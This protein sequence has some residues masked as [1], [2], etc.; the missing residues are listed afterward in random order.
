[1][2]GKMVLRLLA[3][4]G[5]LSVAFTAFPEG[6][7]SI[8]RLASGHAV[9]RPDSATFAKWRSNYQ[10]APRAP[11]I[12][13]AKKFGGGTSCSL[14]ENLQYT[15]SERDQSSCGNCWVWAGTGVLEIA[16]YTQKST[17]DRLSIQ[18]FN[19]NCPNI[20]KCYACD[21]GDL[22]DFVKEYSS[23]G[24]CVPW[25]NTGASWQDGDGSY[26]TKPSQITT[27]PSYTISSITSTTIETYGVTQATAISNIKN[28][29][30]Q[31]KA[32]W[33][34][35]Y[36]PT[37]SDGAK[38]ENF[39]SNDSE[40]TLFSYD[41]W[42]GHTY[43][44]S[45]WGHAV[46]LVGYNDTDSSNRYWIVLNSWGT[47]ANRSNG[48]F[49]LNMD[50][51][52]DAYMMLSGYKDQMLY[53][54]TLDVTYGSGSTTYAISGAVSG[55]VTS[56]VTVTLSGT[57]SATAT[58]ASDGAF[59]ITGLADGTYTV[60]PSKTGYTF[61]PS[62]QSVTIS[63]ANATANFTAAT[64]STT[65]T[66]TGTVSGA[67]TSGITVTLSGTS[68]GTATTAS[69]G[70]YSLTGLANGTYTVTPSKTGYSFTPASQSVTISG[71]NATA[72]F[73]AAASST[74]YS[75]TGTVSGAATSGVTIALSGT[76]SATATTGADGAYSF[77]GLANGSYAL[78]PSKTGY[79][80]TPG[81]RGVTISGAN[82]TADFTDAAATGTYSITGLVSGAATSGV[83]VTLSGT[84][85]GTATTGAD[86][87]YSLAGLVNGVYTITPSKTGYSFTPN[88]H[89]VTI[90]GANATAD[91]TAAAATG[92][93]SITGL[94]SGAATS[95]VTVTLSGTSSATATTA[96]DG[97]YSLAGL[98]N[99]TYTVTPSKTGYSFTPS[100][101]SVTISGANATANF[102]AAATTA[103]LVMAIS[104]ASSGTT[105]P[106]STTTVTIGAATAISAT[107]ATGY[108][109]ANWTASPTANAAFASSTSA[110]TTATLTGNATITAKFSK[111]QYALTVNNGSGGGNYSAGAAVTI[112]ADEAPSLFEFSEWTGD[113]AGIDDIYSSTATLTMPATAAAVTATYKHQTADLTMEVAP[114]DSG[115]T[116][117]EAG[118][119]IAVNLGEAVSITAEPAEGA[120]FV[121]WTAS[122]D[123]VVE[124]TSATATTVTI[125]G[126]A[127]VT[128]VFANLTASKP[129]IKFA[130]THK[131]TLTKSG[132]TYEATGKDTFRVDATFT[133]P[134]DFDYASI[135][136]ST[137]IYFEIEN[138]SFSASLSEALKSSSDQT[139]RGYAVFNLDNDGSEVVTLRWTKG[140]KFHMAIKG[141]PAADSGTN[142]LDLTSLGDGKVSGTIGNCSLL[143][144]SVVW[145]KAD[146]TTFA[147]K[148]TKK[149]TTSQ[150]GGV[151]L[152]G[153]SWNVSG[154]LK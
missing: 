38:F 1:M 66:I 151:T 35:F 52:Y 114:E 3:L 39:W 67:T 16:L 123:A 149:T 117:P 82:A 116:D 106:S 48:L 118:T 14:L 55:A 23:L 107:A 63:G 115:T 138:Y 102:T 74:T 2:P 41:S 112:E 87:T 127:T 18:W 61:T 109:F 88:S 147:W 34:A 69:D 140:K 99:G 26:H 65:Y 60:T 13:S 98:A 153:V 58:T 24:L 125:S 141:K 105:S 124:D 43:G 44:S 81:I 92:T 42:S 86:G 97:T 27:S 111:S 56:G 148:G 32:I 40:S 53:F 64:S 19:A 72:N 150:R 104:P 22:E 95:G 15:P 9:M 142:I 121:H 46:L 50:S 33:F 91:F 62:S 136:D 10:N 135:D 154:T 68:S 110:S 79:T 132:G 144:G 84:S 6:G 31:G 100:S 8:S 47:T 139:K 11:I 146:S 49:R 4:I 7:Q 90:S 45:G 29:I 76:S 85:S 30:D 70:T 77:T 12:S 103:S 134:A 57:S 20:L 54:Q 36:A 145:I 101:Q 5:A 80:F 21:G 28:V 93:Y 130:S 78:T 131:D 133:L 59:S 129:I 94:V 96:S 17:K 75:I 122:G 71:A 51:A 119:S 152:D 126:D 113:V 37:G 108:Q 137:E 89:S 120:V 25:S 73:T 143:F 128:A 83:T